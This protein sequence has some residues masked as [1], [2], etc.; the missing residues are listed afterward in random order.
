VYASLHKYLDFLADLPN[1]SEEELLSLALNIGATNF[2]VMELLDYGHTERYGHPTPTKV[3][4]SHKKGKAILVSGHDIRDLEEV[5]IRTS[6]TGINVYTHGELLPAHGYPGLHKYPHLAGNYGGAWQ[7]QKIE[8]A[9]FP[10]PVLVTTNCMIEP[11]KSYKDR[12]YTRHTVGWEEVKHISDFTGFDALVKHALELEGF[13]NDALQETS[14]TVGFGRNAVLELADKVLEAVSSGDIK[15]F[16]VVGGCDGSEAQR[17]YFKDIAE[18][19]PRDAVVMT[20]GC[21]KYRFNKTP[22]ETTLGGLPRL[23]DVGQC[24]DA[25]SAIQIASALAKALHTD[26]NGLPIHFAISWFEQKA[27]AVLLTM[28]HLN[29]KNIHLGPKL[30]AFVTPKVLKILNEGFGLT[31]VDKAQKDLQ[32]FITL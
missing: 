32:K 30:P 29:I 31:P 11:M 7:M 19:A 12:L 23:L 13:E 16:F 9:K 20:M 14:I 17:S 4:T 3:L 22:F 21:G 8:F 6:G 24:N 28:L 10:G 25:Y 15:H 27:V 26:V 5:L 2:R 18:N 1:R